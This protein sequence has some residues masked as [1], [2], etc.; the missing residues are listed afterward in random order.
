[1]ILAVH[2]QFG[3]NVYAMLPSG[4]PVLFLSDP[5][6]IDSVVKATG[7]GEDFGPVE[8]DP[9]QTSGAQKR[10]GNGTVFTG[11]REKWQAQRRKMLP[12]FKP[13][14]VESPESYNP[15]IA[16]VQSRMKKLADRVG[17]GKVVDIQTDV[18]NSVLEIVLRSLLHTDVDP[19]NIEENLRPGLGAAM[20]WMVIDTAFNPT[21][22]DMTRLPTVSPAQGRAKKAYETLFKLVD[23]TIQEHE[24]HPRHDMVNALL[25]DPSMSREDVRKVLATI[26][27]AS[28]ETTVSYATWSLNEI[29]RNPKIA[30]KLHQDLASHIGDRP[31]TPKDKTPYL[32]GVLDETL[33]FYSPFFFM[34]RRAKTDISL[35]GPGGKLNI[36]AG[37]HI[38]LSSLASQRRETD[39]GVERT[40]YPANVYEP[41]RWSPD[42]PDR[43]PESNLCAFGSGA[44]LCIGMQFAKAEVRLLVSQI[45]QNFDLKPVSPQQPKIGSRVA[46]HPIGGLP[47]YVSPRTDTGA[48]SYAGAR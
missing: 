40:G 20:K 2:E 42:N 15:M 6:Q 46:T 45:A 9:L 32:D 26:V 34:M 4:E 10:F 21:S 25:T 8:R 23:R 3:P 1:M 16:V 18:E 41:E 39:W 7:P 35:A 28:F 47:L 13:S 5:R 33:R 30:D 44:H 14:V 31:V 36:P 38:V 24:A 48:A 29:A 22:I 37:T 12:Y 43:P 17:K 11:S 19:K 27:A